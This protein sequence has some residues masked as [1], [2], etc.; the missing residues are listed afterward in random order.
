MG[1]YALTTSKLCKHYGKSQIL[2]NITISVPSKS[3][4]GLIGEMGLERQHFSVF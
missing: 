4:Y 3:I 1:D 2:E